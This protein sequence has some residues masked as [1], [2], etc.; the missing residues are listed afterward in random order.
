MKRSLRMISLILLVAM[1]LSMILPGCSQ[2]P[3][4][5]ATEAPVTEPV[6]EPATEPATE[7]PVEEY[8]EPIPDG[9]NQVTFY[10]TYDG[11]YETCDMW[12]WM[13]G[14][15]GKGYTFHEC[16]YGGKV[17]VN[18]PEDVT[19]IGFIVRRDCSEPGGTSWGSAT[20]DY[21]SDR[22]AA[23]EGKETVIYLQPGD[24]AQYKSSDGG[25]TLTQSKKF[26]MASLADERAINYKITPKTT[27]SDLSKVKVY[28]NGKE[29]TVAGLSTLGKE[30]ANGT[31]ELSE[32][33]DLS[34]AYKVSIEGY[35]EQTVIPMEIFDSQ[36]FAD[37][38]HYDGNDLGAT[39]LGNTTTFK[40]WAPTAS[41]VVLNLF[42]AGDGGEAYESVEMVKGD[43][44][45]WSHTAE[46][47]HG[48]Y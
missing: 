33:L 16:E 6:T 12:I 9:H 39:I 47:G 11:A 18:V 28:K 31:I 32:P 8:F 29:V 48:T 25:K 44:G 15:D 27:V 5:T 30:A 2:A 35:G 43:K 19:E 26:N 1:A 3:E 4:Q 10:W 37:N 34:A 24:P 23:I 17:I 7:P 13:P 20:K 21:E 40:V 42:E 14:K 46:C 22:F 36:F 45:V 38:Y 41:K